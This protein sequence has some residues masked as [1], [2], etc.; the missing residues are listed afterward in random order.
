MKEIL[1][2]SQ[3]INSFFET[4][5]KNQKVFFNHIFLNYCSKYAV[6]KDFGGIG[7]EFQ[8]I[9]KFTKALTKETA[10]LGI[11]LSILINMLIL[12]IISIYGNDEQKEKY[13]KSSI[14][15]GLVFS[16]AVSE[17]K[18]GPHP[19]YLKSSAVKNNSLYVLNGEKT[20]TTNAPI[21]DYSIVIAITSV[22]ERK[23][24]SA[25]F[26]P[27]DNTNV[28]IE[29]I[30]NLPFFKDCPHGSI[31]FTNFET[32]E[33]E[34]LGKIDKAYDE[35]VM[36]FRK[37]EDILM[38]GP[39]LGVFEYL[40]HSVLKKNKDIDNKDFLYE[41][42][43]IIASVKTL[44]F[45]CEKAC[46]ELENNKNTT[47][48]IHLFL[49]DHF[50]SLIERLNNLALKFELDFENTEKEILEDLSSSGKIAF[51]SAWTKL[52][53]LAESESL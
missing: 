10:N 42:G 48:F 36:S 4:K 7:G 5:D 24:Y 13:L 19:K 34:I 2:L 21:C 28:L 23:N 17:P 1:K 8:D 16:F 6:N 46:I 26:V 44:D 41:S 45:L 31:K 51:K 39:I 22:D 40:I 14:E 50:K 25:F 30:E 15:K 43:A 29:P 52:V 35:I 12:K 3:E 9:Y 32:N 18:A 33:K 49:R 47:E 38:A 11:S 37:Y 53:K 27:S 20:F